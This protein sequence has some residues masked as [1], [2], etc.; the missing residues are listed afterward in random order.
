MFEILIKILKKIF[1]ELIEYPTLEIEMIQQ[2]LC[3]TTTRAHTQTHYDTLFELQS[4][5]YK[6]QEEKQITKRQKY[7][8]SQIFPLRERQKGWWDKNVIYIQTNHS[9][10]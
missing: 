2:A 1:P 9:L 5:T 10:C 8:W 4:T 3:E 7:G 6:I